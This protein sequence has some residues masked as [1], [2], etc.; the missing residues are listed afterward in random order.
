MLLSSLVVISVIYA[1]AC[2]WDYFHD[3]QATLRVRASNLIVAFGCGLLAVDSVLRI[4]SQL[5]PARG[6]V[7]AIILMLYGLIA[8]SIR[9]ASSLQKQKHGMQHV[10]S[11]AY[12][13]DR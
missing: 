3:E 1:I 9:S 7:F 11:Q 8:P 2:L 6:T 13:P 10:H 4:V 5:E 12:R